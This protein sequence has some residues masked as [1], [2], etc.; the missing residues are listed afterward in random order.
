MA[1]IVTTSQVIAPEQAGVLPAASHPREQERESR[2]GRGHPSGT[3][4]SVRG[5][6]VP[7]AGAERGHGHGLGRQ[8]RLPPRDPACAGHHARFRCRG[9]SG[10]AGPR[11]LAPGRAAP[12]SAAEICRCCLSALSCLAHRTG[13]Y[14]EKRLD[15]GKADY[16]CRGRTLPMHQ[17]QGLGDRARRAGGLYDGGRRGAAANRGDCGRAG[18]GLLRLGHDMGGARR[19]DRALPRQRAP[20]GPSTGRW[21]ACWW[22]PSCRCSGDGWHCA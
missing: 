8:F 9:D 19:G 6:H 1:L 2:D 12:A 20:A 21:P 22:F 16:L 13:R 10:G 5:R 7:D 18:G 3:L 17:P 4:G 11:R 15:A 14:G